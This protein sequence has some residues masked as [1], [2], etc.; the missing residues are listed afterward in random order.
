[1]KV[2]IISHFNSQDIRMWSGS[3]Y[4]L[5]KA[6]ENQNI[7]VIYIGGLK[8]KN[9]IIQ[10]IKYKIYNVYLKKIWDINR[11]PEN[12]KYYAKQIK[13]QLDKNK[14]DIILSI[15]EKPLAFLEYSKPIVFLGDAVFSLLINNYPE[16]SNF[17]KETIRNGHVIQKKAL[18]KSDLILLSSKWASKAA[19]N[20][21]GADP[22]KIKLFDFGANYENNISEKDVLS[23]INNRSNEICKLLFIGVEW[24]R[25]GGDIVLKITQELN[26]RGLKTV[27]TVLGSEPPQ[28]N[29]NLDCVTYCGFIDKTTHE[30]QLEFIN[31]IKN[32][33]FLVLPTKADCSPV[34]FSEANSLGIPCISTN[35]GGISSVIH[36]NVNGK[37][38]DLNDSTFEYENYILNLFENYSS[39]QELAKSSFNE[40]RNRLNWKVTGKK[41]KNYFAETIRDYN[42]SK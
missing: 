35:V 34:V 31:I 38:F 33:H 32:H 10:K 30:G 23:L 11:D 36:N 42:N 19:V 41:I 27:L 24:E 29:I 17:C 15:A 5:G 8:S 4:N 1:M 37:L 21:Y 2:A 16:Y 3:A 13:K 40:Y 22:K 20:D 14:P 28:K 39:Y 9:N 25:K 6:L 12:L 26:N 18:L 7:D